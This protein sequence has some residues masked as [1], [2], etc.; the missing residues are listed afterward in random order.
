MFCWDFINK[1]NKT[2]ATPHT[3]TP[4]RH[5]GGLEGRKAWI[6]PRAWF[7][8]HLVAAQLFQTIR[9]ESAATDHP[10]RCWPCASSK[11]LQHTHTY[12]LKTYLKVPSNNPDFWPLL[13][14]GQNQSVCPLLQP[15]WVFPLLLLIVVDYRKCLERLTF[16]RSH[17]LSC[18]VAESLWAWW[19]SWSAKIKRKE[20]LLHFVT[21]NESL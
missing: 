15:W 5:R 13:N 18:V 14:L 6:S 8:L 9:L 16:R 3:P 10:T 7:V 1:A 2:R 20:A 19:C 17:N 11:P 21:F 4:T 12:T